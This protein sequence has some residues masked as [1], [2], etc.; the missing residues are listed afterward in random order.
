[1]LHNIR[2]IVLHSTPY[3]DRHCITLVYTEQFGSMSYLT[4][5]Y[6]KQSK[7]IP[8]ALFHPLSALE[9]TA[10]HYHNRDIHR[11]KEARSLLPL[12][13]LSGNPVKSAVSFFIAEVIMKT[14]REEASNRWLFDYILQSVTI[15]EQSTRPVTNFHIAFLFG[16]CRHLGFEPNTSEY[17]DGDFFDLTAGC[18]TV[19]RPSHPHCLN[20]G[21]SRILYRLSRISY[22]NMHV[23]RFSGS[24][25]TAVVHHILSYYRLHLYPF[26]TVKSLEVLHSVFS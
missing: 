22:R 13:S 10:V 20:A 23:F 26:I 16:L 9:M 18:Y 3:N 7:K 19:I 8:R 5:R 21:S 2:G 11:I 25:R 15:L 12:I 4:P 1:M 17:R 24:E 6:T 14:V